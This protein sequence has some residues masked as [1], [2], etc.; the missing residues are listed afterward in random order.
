MQ[1]DHTKQS[2]KNADKPKKPFR[3]QPWAA[4]NGKLGGRPPEWDEEKIA[5]FAEKLIKWAML[6]TSCYLESFC[7]QNGTYP[8]KLSELAEKNSRFSEALKFARSSLASNLAEATAG[9]EIPPAFGI[10]ALKNVG[11]WTDRQEIEHSGGLKNTLQ[12]YIPAKK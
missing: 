2:K 8:Q 7:K 4:E 6:H 1:M 10:F 5:D 3:S 12:I 9:G 11:R